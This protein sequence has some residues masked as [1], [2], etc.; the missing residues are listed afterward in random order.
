MEE[1]KPPASGCLERDCGST[2]V[3]RS[4]ISA[5]SAPRITAALYGLIKYSF[6]VS[7]ST[8]SGFPSILPVILLRNFAVHAQVHVEKRQC[9]R[10]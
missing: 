10:Y 9:K 4:G 8:D 1:C 6:G 7:Y 5:R 3:S 2:T